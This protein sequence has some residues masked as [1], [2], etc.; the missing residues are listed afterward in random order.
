MEPNT[1]TTTFTSVTDRQRPILDSAR[2]MRPI[3]LASDSNTK[4]HTRGGRGFRPEASLIQ[5]LLSIV[6]A[7]LIHYGDPCWDPDTRT[8]RFRDGWT[9]IMNTLGMYASKPSRDIINGCLAKMMRFPVPST[10][11]C[12]AVQALDL[13]AGRPASKTVTFG[14]K[15]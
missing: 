10:H 14:L 11:Q 7:T 5:S 9:N 12:I 15:G 2:Y 1:E 4:T 6:F 8:I 13:D 3:L